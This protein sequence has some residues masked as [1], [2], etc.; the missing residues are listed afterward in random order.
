MDIK[1]LVNNYLTNVIP[2]N[3]GI[4]EI[5]E[6]LEGGFKPYTK[7]M[8]YGEAGTWKTRISLKLVENAPKDSSPVFISCK[9]SP[10]S[11]TQEEEHFLHLD[12]VANINTYLEK[13]L[14]L[15]PAKNRIIVIDD[16]DYIVNTNIGEI[17]EMLTLLNKIIYRD[18]GILVVT[19]GVSQQPGDTKILR[20]RLPKIVQASIDVHVFL[21]REKDNSIRIYNVSIGK[22]AIINM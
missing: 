1:T 21:S 2:I 15:P 22:S 18:Q 10:I 13:L 19:S 20:P 17:Y 14:S 5:D 7:Y 6:V 9:H 16:L 4:P 3:T 8:L 12:T 11:T